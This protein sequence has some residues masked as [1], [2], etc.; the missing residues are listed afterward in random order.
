MD[1]IPSSEP[2]TMSFWHGGKLD[3]YSEVKYKK[4]RWEYGPGLYLT[5]NYT[6]AQEYSRGGRLLYM[7]TIK[8][9]TDVSEINIPVAL[10][11]DFIDTY[12]IQKKQKECK[13]RTDARSKNSIVSLQYVQNIFVNG[14]YLQ[15]SNV[16]ELNK[17][18]KNNGADYC[19][20]SRTFGFDSNMCVL[21]NTKLIVDTKV[22]KPKDKIIQFDLDNIFQ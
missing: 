13:E 2:R 9:G 1:I 14:E 5:T 18:L 15:T 11:Q 12:V 8:K 7:I 16:G 6:T 3:F 20:L 21:Y 17:F 4:G 19:M 10:V 22:V